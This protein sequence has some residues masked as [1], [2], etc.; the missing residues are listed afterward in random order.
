MSWMTVLEARR[1]EIDGKPVESVWIDM[2]ER[3]VPAC[4]ALDAVCEMMRRFP[5]VHAGILFGPPLPNGKGPEHEMA[6]MDPGLVDAFANDLLPGARVIDAG[7]VA[8]ATDSDGKDS[9]FIGPHLLSDEL[10]V[11]QVYRR[12]VKAQ[13]QR[14]RRD[15]CAIHAPTLEEF[16]TKCIFA[17]QV[18]FGHPPRK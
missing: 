11:V 10:T 6:V 17:P 13:V 2:L 18:K 5:I 8:F 3:H 12:K 4:P 7:Y 1:P 15:Q 9:H 16:F 14:L